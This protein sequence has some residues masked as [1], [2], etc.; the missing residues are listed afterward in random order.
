MRKLPDIGHGSIA[1]TRWVT[2]KRPKIDRIAC[3]W[4]VRRFVDPLAAFDYVAPERVLEAA[5]ASGAVPYDVPNVQFAHRGERCSFDAILEDFGLHDPALDALAVIVRGA[6]TA[7]LD[8]APQAAGLLAVSL[9]LSRNFADDAAMLE[10]GMPVYD[11]LY[12]WCREHGRNTP[13]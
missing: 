2:R 5:R 13:S 6:D 4:L 8:L 11:A 3:P 10:A 9:G 7:R 1:A 12:A